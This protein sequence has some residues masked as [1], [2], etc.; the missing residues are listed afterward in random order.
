MP[1]LYPSVGSQGGLPKPEQNVSKKLIDRWKNAGDKTLVPSLPGTGYESVKIPATQV[2]F[3]YSE[4]RYLL[5]NR[6]DMRVAN[7]DFI[8]CRLI[9]HCL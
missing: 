7:T 4:N 6:S 5:Y 2:S 8:R 1:E 3:G 9:S